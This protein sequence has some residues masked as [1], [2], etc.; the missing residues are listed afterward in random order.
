MKSEN[1]SSIHVFIHE[2]HVFIHLW[3]FAGGVDFLT[4]QATPVDE[5]TANGQRGKKSDELMD[6]K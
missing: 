2:T 3:I 1:H 4:Q 6:E 5:I